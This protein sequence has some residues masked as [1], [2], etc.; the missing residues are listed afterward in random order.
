MPK[1]TKRTWKDNLKKMF[2]VTTD[3]ELEEKLGEEAPVGDDGVG[4]SGEGEG[5]GVTIHNHMHPGGDRS[6]DDEGDLPPWFT[7]HVLQNNA[8]FD[9]LNSKFDGLMEQIGAGDKARD[10][11]PDDE[12]D[13]K[14]EDADPDDKDD[15]KAEDGEA[16][17]EA[18]APPGTGDKARKAKDSAFF[19][20]SFQE[21]ISIAEILVPGIGLPTYDA[22]AKPKV[23][24]DALCSLRRRALDKAAND[25]DLKGLISATLAGRSLDKMSCDAI[26]TLFRAA[27]AMRKASSGDVG[28][29][30]L[31]SRGAGGGLGIATNRKVK[32]L[33]DI[34]KMNAEHYKR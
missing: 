26:R 20:D 12:D 23:T 18:E 1:N 24:F 25:D 6:R 19:A 16:A 15:K 3:E 14:S 33:A 9:E 8:R 27:G 22:K 2:G 11:D 10:A 29:R 21:T 13:K 28:V 5:A 7:E 4:E 31:A 34:N 30:D 17:F 32:S